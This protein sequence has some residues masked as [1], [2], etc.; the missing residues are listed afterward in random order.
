MKNSLASWEFVTS[1]VTSAPPRVINFR[2]RILVI[3]VGF[4][5]G[6]PRPAIGFKRRRRAGRRRSKDTVLTADSEVVV[7]VSDVETGRDE[8]CERKHKGNLFFS[9]RVRS[10][11]QKMSCERL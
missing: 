4:R 7:N 1:G 8:E 10:V 3:F 5:E 9:A 2:A 11:S 6:P